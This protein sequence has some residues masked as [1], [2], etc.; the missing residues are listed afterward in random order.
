MIDGY[1]IGFKSC[2]ER[3][4]AG[5]KLVSNFSTENVNSAFFTMT[6]PESAPWANC[7]DVPCEI[8][9][10]DPAEA[11]CQCQVVETGPSLT[12]GGG[13]D[14]GTCTSVIWS[15]APLG[16]L[17]LSQYESGMECVNQAVTLP[18]MCPSATPAASPIATPSS[19]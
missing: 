17:G 15:A 13:C 18:P 5:D 2:V 1:A 6:C 11:T 16:L 7:L 10:L 3:A 19:G 14:T 4:P 8:D 12:F 9:P